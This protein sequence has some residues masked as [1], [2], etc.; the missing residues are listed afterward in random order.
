MSEATSGDQT[1]NPELL[2]ELAD[3]FAARFRRGE[4]PSVNDYAGRYP[5]LANEIHELFPA[6][7]VM[8]KCGFETLP[9]SLY[10]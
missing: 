8:E 7:L 9:M 4:R 2:A 3:D 6:L 10:Q 5:A 1:T